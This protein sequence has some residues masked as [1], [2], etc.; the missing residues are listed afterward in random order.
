MLGLSSRLSTRVH[1]P[2]GALAIPAWLPAP[3]SGGAVLRWYSASGLRAAAAGAPAVAAPGSGSSSLS[4]NAK[5]KLEKE[6][7]AKKKKAKTLQIKV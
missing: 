3:G 5:A 1:A 6:K 2:S 4:G 7:R